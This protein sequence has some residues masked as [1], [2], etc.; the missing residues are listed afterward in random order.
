M[1]ACVSLLRVNRKA[2]TKP[3]CLWSWETH[4][5]IFSA[6]LWVKLHQP[7]GGGLRLYIDF[8]WRAKLGI[9]SVKNLNKYLGKSLLKVV[10]DI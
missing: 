2:G 9:E 6:L 3:M 5:G 4:L 1:L 10:V 7:G 8:V